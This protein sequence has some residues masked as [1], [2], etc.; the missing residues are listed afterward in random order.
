MLPCQFFIGIFLDQ[1]RFLQ[2]INNLKNQHKFLLFVNFQ[3]FKIIF[4]DLTTSD[5][6]IRELVF[7]IILYHIFDH[8]HG[9]LDTLGLFVNN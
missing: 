5:L 2:I 6:Q 9:H 1:Y 3:S 8:G 7:C 4:D